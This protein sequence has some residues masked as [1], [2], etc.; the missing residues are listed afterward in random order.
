M[1][2]L[3]SIGKDPKDLVNSKSKK[4]R[5]IIQELNILTKLLPKGMDALS[6]Y[7]G[8]KKF[9]PKLK[10]EELLIDYYTTGKKEPK[11]F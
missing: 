9:T 7:N 4:F 11:L 5:K 3:I 1:K 2:R 6:W 8:I 10:N